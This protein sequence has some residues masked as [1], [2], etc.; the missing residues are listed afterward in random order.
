M[1]RTIAIGIACVGLA[2]ACG[3]SKSGG[4][5]CPAGEITVDGQKLG[6]KYGLASLADGFT[7]I[8][9]YDH[10]KVTCEEIVAT[11]MADIM[12][13]TQERGKSNDEFSVRVSAG[14]AN[15]IGLGANTLMDD[16]KVKAKL[17]SKADK[18]GDNVAICLTEPAEY[19]LQVGRYEGKKLVMKGLFEGKYCGE[20]K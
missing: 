16:S 7:M 17:V 18:V 3:K 13:L 20:R 4:D 11:K 10:D 5:S 8:Q 2:A 1:L 12:R 15:S 9:L 14:K 6:H 19:V